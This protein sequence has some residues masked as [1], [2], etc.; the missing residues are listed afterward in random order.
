MGL[1]IFL[2]TYFR[3]FVTL[4]TGFLMMISENNMLLSNKGLAYIGNISYSL[5]LIHW[6]VYA[7]WKL[8]CEGDQNCEFSLKVYYGN[9]KLQECM[10]NILDAQ[11]IS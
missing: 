4:V 5:Y 6:P 8:T 2:L 7:Y 10:H 9:A 11:N 3:P 1:I